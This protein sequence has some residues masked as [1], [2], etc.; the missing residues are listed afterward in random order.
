MGW[1]CCIGRSEMNLESGL[2]AAAR[3]VRSSTMA[4]MTSMTTF[5]GT[6]RLGLGVFER[7]IRENV[8]LA[9]VCTSR[10]FPH[11]GV[12]DRMPNRSRSLLSRVGE[13]SRLCVLSFLAWRHCSK[14]SRQWCGGRW[15]KEMVSG[16]LLVSPGFWFMSRLMSLS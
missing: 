14:R 15:R 1:G 2:A 12:L 4:L 7:I 13:S 11:D 3:A 16:N 10:A 5:S 6:T 8:A 9:S